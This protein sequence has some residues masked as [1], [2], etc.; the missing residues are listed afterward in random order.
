MASIESIDP[1]QFHRLRSSWVRSVRQAFLLGAC[2]ADRE[3]WVDVVREVGPS[4][5]W[6]YEFRLL[7]DMLVGIEKPTAANVANIK[8]RLMISEK[9]PRTIL[10]QCGIWL[11][12][13]NLETRRADRE[14]AICKTD[15]AELQ[16]MFAK[17]IDEIGRF[18]DETR[19]RL[20]LNK[21]S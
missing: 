4:D 21:L 14:A 1:E 18:L 8:R 11:R 3:K 13:S 17:E 10:E 15:N 12:I 20:E 19:E 16:E 6:S 9:S 5:E 7:V 2:I